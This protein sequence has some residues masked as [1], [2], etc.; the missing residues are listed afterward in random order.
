MRKGC[1][2][3]LLLLLLPLICAAEPGQVG[4]NDSLREKPF[5]DAKAVATLKA[6]Q[7]VEILKRQ[8]AWY[9]VT[10][11][12]KTGWTPMLSVRRT[13]AAAAVSAGSLA[14]TASGRAATGKVVATTGVRGLNEENLEEATFSEAAVAALEKYRVT[15]QAADSF[16]RDAGLAPREVPSLGKGGKK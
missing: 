16:A 10:A 9:Q 3:A 7:K 11:A 1:A 8:G 2:G 15:P 4:R 12:G 13:A 6:G 14:Q 5:T